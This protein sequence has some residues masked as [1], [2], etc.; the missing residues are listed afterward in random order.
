MDILQKSINSLSKNEIINYKIYANRQYASDKRKDIA[1]FDV[2]NK[3]KKN[4]ADTDNFITKIYPSGTDKSVYNRL[5]YRLLDEIDNS[6]VQFYF[7]KIDTNYIYSELSLYHIYLSKNE[8]DVAYYHLSRAE[9]KAI[10]IQQ[11]ILLDVVYTEFIKLSIYYGKNSPDVYIKKRNDNNVQ[12]KELR[13][14]DDTIAKVIY[15]LDRNQTY[16]KI[17][18]ENITILNNAI[19][20]LNKRKELKNNVIFKSK[21][22]ALVSQLLLSKKD[23]IALEVFCINNYSEFEKNNF[24]SKNN[25]GV[26]LQMLRYICNAL[27]VNKKQQQAL[28]YI[29]LFYKAMLEF[30]QE[31]YAKNVFFYYSALANNYSELNPEKA[32]DVLNDAKKTPAI[33]GHP[34]HLCYVYINLGGAYFDIG[35]YKLGLKNIL[36]V[37]SHPFYEILDESVKFQIQLLDIILR[38]ETKQYDVAQKNI[39]KLKNNYIKQLQKPEYNDEFAFL[40]L[41][42]KVVTNTTFAK[43]KTDIDLISKYLKLKQEQPNNSFINFNKWLKEKFETKI[44]KNNLNK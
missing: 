23:F 36:N 11:F 26:K 37:F 1:L 27:F 25:H 5:K 40:T 41:L 2:L 43:A 10:A 32:I 16:A 33:I 24:F 35:Q 8:W 38:I 21:L 15:D 31:Y 14:I 22:F 29:E 6:L 28:T 42:E 17:K 39:V 30:K 34:S 44:Q 3:N 13:L 7:H 4:N 19:S 20:V 18:I 9:K 12:L